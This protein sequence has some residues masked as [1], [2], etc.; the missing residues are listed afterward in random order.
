[1]AVCGSAPSSPFTEPEPSVR[2]KPNRVVVHTAAFLCYTAPGRHR[3]EPLF[4]YAFTVGP[5]LAVGEHHVIPISGGARPSSR[6]RASSLERSP[7][8]PCTP[9]RRPAYA[10]DAGHRARLG[11]SSFASVAAFVN[12]RTTHCSALVS[13]C[14]V[15]S[16]S[17]PAVR[18]HPRVSPPSRA[19][20]FGPVRAQGT[21]ARTHLSPHAHA[22]VPRGL[23]SSRPRLELAAELSPLSI[24]VRARAH[25]KP[26][27][28]AP[29]TPSRT[30]FLFPRLNLCEAESCAR[31]HVC[32]WQAKRQRPRRPRRAT[33]LSPP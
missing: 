12:V 14:I 21:R 1:L 30:A 22:H 3:V 15:V 10:G 16:A 28:P 32:A 9:P 25:S 23:A 27:S 17:M 8:S 19:A 5:L 13:S 31:P 20:R 24:R 18:A 6:G 11:K 2:G 26:T 4:P 7:L 29:V 33:P